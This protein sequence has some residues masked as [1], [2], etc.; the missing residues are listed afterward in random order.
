VAEK[1]VMMQ[2]AELHSIREPFKETHENET[3]QKNSELI[4]ESRPV[5]INHDLWRSPHDNPTSPET[6]NIELLK[7]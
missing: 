2:S 6:Q 1:E 3:L 7:A 4:T 5:E